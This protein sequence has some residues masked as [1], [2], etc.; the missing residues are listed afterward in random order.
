M[1]RRYEPR[2]AQGV[3]DTVREVYEEYG[4]TWDPEEYHADLFSIEAEYQHADAEFWVAELDGLVVGCVGLVCFPALPGEFGS[5]T[6]IDGTVRVAAAD[7]EL[8]RLYV[9]PSARQ[10]GLGSQL[11][12]VVLAEARRRNRRVME[13]WSDKRFDK[14]HRL[15]LRYGAIIV[16]DRICDDPD[17][18]PEY[19]L[20]I[21]LTSS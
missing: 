12:E 16:G 5:T 3:Q 19:G 8:V 7:C 21:D 2:D 13:L 11:T 10:G 9:R 4:F 18:S 20:A 1:I 17:E 6:E 15:Y 14:A